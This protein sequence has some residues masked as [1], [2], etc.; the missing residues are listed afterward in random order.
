VKSK[1]RP[2]SLFLYNLIKFTTIVACVSFIGAV[3][4]LLSE[5]IRTL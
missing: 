4:Y 3:I 1:V 5:W 2:R